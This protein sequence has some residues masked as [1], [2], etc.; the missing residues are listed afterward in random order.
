MEHFF[1]K[2]Y[3]IAKDIIFE[4]FKIVYYWPPSLLNL[5]FD[6]NFWTTP[7]TPLP[8]LF[9]SQHLVDRILI[10][11]RVQV[12]DLLNKCY[13]EIHNYSTAVAQI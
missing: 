1:T 11:M 10:L 12:Y 13:F 5:A 2:F 7:P 3:F 9:F 6:A 8:S 4:K